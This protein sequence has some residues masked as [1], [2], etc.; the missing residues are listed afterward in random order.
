MITDVINMLLS[1]IVAII[2]QYIHIL[3]G[4]MH[5]LNIYNFCWLYLNKAG[6]SKEIQAYRYFCE[7]AGMAFQSK[8]QGTRQLW[9]MDTLEQICYIN[10]KN[11]PAIL[12]PGKAQRPFLHQKP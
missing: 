1:F 4:N 3:K 5:T 8:Q 7:D 2:S 10:P 11:L 6:G 12:Y 9:K